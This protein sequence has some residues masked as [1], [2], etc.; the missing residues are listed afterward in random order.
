[1][2]ES[3]G[4]C[5]SSYPNLCDICGNGVRKPPEICDDSIQNDDKGCSEDCMNMLPKWTCSGGTHSSPDIC[6]PKYG[7]SFI[8][9][10]EECDD[11]NTLDEDGCSS[12]GLIEQGYTCLNTPCEENCTPL[13][14]TCTLI[15]ET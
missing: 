7:D 2:I 12:T 10:T 8:V 14:S 3:N 11:G 9:S 15:S 5:T 13:P 4:H 1:M 6:H